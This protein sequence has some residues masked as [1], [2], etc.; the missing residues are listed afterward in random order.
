DVQRMSAGTG[1]VHSEYN[2]SKSDPVHFLQIW[3]VPSERGIKP[4]Y[5]QKTFPDAEKQGRVRLIASRDGGDGRVTI[6]TDGT[7]YAGL[8]DRGQTAEL[9]IATGRHA[10]VHVARG[11]AKVNGRELGEGDGLSLSDERMV[12]IEGVD[13]AELIVFDLG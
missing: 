9:P 8:F 12:T 1:V 5:E 10:W 3:L 4:G 11:A 2:A 13:H 6:H 7:V